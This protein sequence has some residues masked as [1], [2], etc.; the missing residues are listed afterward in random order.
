[1]P[2]YFSLAIIGMYCQQYIILYYTAETSKI[3][4]QTCSNLTTFCLLKVYCSSIGAGGVF[5]QGS[6][7]TIIDTKVPRIVVH[8]YL[9]SKQN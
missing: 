4:L 1:M 6:K 3:G 7:A 5:S 2:L 9:L 8:T